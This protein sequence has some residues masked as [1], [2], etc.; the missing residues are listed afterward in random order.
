MTDFVFGFGSLFGSINR[1][2]PVAYLTC[3]FEVSERREWWTLMLLDLHRPIDFK[4]LM[5]TIRNVTLDSHITYFILQNIPKIWCRLFTLIQF[6]NSLPHQYFTFLF[7]YCSSSIFIYIYI[8]YIW[9]IFCIYFI[10]FSYFYI[11]C[12][13]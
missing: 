11:F 10:Y 5:I 7:L 6:F 12:I 2:L 8:I 3:L 4:Q 13:F 9:Y 1:K